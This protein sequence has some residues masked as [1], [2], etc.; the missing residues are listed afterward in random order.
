[1]ATV[2]G[3]RP[4][5]RAHVLAVLCELGALSRAELARRTALA[6]STVSAIVN[7]LAEEGLVAEAERGAAATAS[8]LGRPPTLVALHRRAG[9]SAGIDF[10]KRHVRVALADLAHTILAER[11]RAVDDDLPAAESIALAVELFDEVLAEAGAD[12]AEV[13]GVGM[14]LPGP[15]QQSTGELGDSTI[16]P[17][18]VGVRA[19]EAM[20]RTLELPV[21][22]GNDA[23]L[24][25]LAEWMW[26][27]G[28]D[29][30]D[31]VYIKVATGIGSGL[32]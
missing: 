16:L 20:Q 25:A 1:M 8:G 12:R 13:V 31:V 18:W 32:V 23:N 27:A 14:G 5:A 4:K 21:E 19:A 9:V 17:G 7:E 26:G 24:G 28:H 22:I 3:G 10:G 11:R 15:V 29:C 2:V 30:D 6:P